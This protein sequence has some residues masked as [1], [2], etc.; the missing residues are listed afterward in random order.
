MKVKSLEIRKG[1]HY[2]DDEPDGLFGVVELVSSNGTVHTRLSNR[3]LGKIF[4]VIREDVVEQTKRNA[5]GVD[6][7]I[8]DAANEHLLLE[9]IIDNED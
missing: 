1:E 7:A 9:N 4:E 3:S 6:K 2:R 8:D 5:E